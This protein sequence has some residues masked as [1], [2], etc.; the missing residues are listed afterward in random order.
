[1]RL[2]GCGVAL[3]V[4]VIAS[5]LAI[6]SSVSP[7][8]DDCKGYS[9]SNIIEEPFKVQADLDLIGDGCGVY[10]PDVAKL[11]VLV[12]YQTGTSG[13]SQYIIMMASNS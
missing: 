10:G 12:E 3:A 8:I 13:R 5:D 4:G 2:T 9:V 6:A 1:M 7:S 11:K